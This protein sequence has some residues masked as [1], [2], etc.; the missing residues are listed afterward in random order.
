MAILKGKKNEVWFQVTAVG[1]QGE[2]GPQGPQGEP[3]LQGP[4]GEPGP[5]GPQG[6]PGLQGPQGPQGEIGPAGANGVDGFSPSAKVTQTETGATITITDKDGTTEATIESGSGGMGY[7]YKTPQDYGAV[8]NG[9]TDDTIAFQQA[10]SENNVVFVPEGT[11]KLNGTLV[12]RENCGLQ[13]S[14]RTLLKFGL[15][16]GNCIEMRGSASLQGNHGNI[17]VPQ[18]FTGNV[19]SV[20]T[21]LDGTNHAS[22]PPYQKSTPMWKRARYITDV[23]ITK[24]YR[25]NEN[26]QYQGAYLSTDEVSGT[27]LYISAN[28]DGGDTNPITY[29]WAMTCS[30]IRIAGAFEYG[31]NIENRD[32]DGGS[33]NE[34]DPAWNHDMRIEAVVASCE[35]GVRVYNCNT[36]HLAVTIQPATVITTGAPY[37]KNGIVLEDSKNIDLSSSIVWDWDSSNT[38]VGTNSEYTHIALYGNCRGLILS[39]FRYYEISPNVRESIYT[40]YSANYD[41]MI[42]LQEPFTRWFKPIEVDGEKRPYFYNGEVNQELCLKSTF[43]S[44]FG[45]Y[46]EEKHYVNILPV[47][48]KVDGEDSYS[49]TGW[50]LETWINNSGYDISQEYSWATGFIPITVN[51][52]IYIKGLTDLPQLVYYY[53]D[54]TYGGHQ[55]TPG[56]N[57]QNSIQTSKQRE[58]GIIEITFSGIGTRRYVRLRQY[59]GFVVDSDLNNLE[60]SRTDFSSTIVATISDNIKIDGSQ[61]INLDSYYLP[62]STKTTQISSASDNTVIPTA[63]AVYDYVQSAI[64]AALSTQ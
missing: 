60:V 4:Q 29:I 6:E 48:Q 41:N 42:V 43:E 27:G 2:T 21:G 12:I 20:D 24:T 64:A 38:L 57:G 32:K 36:A 3:G 35:T 55:N 17:D 54:K 34:K 44:V 16:T 51:E 30:G 7:P 14:Q 59:T 39:D 19:I 13:L 33:S 62:V 9:T 46:T 31:I 63:K 25:E 8:G 26:Q 1:P 18:S 52:T 5:Q 15:T 22:I 47:S 10:M 53:E 50:K 37:A 23:N 28:F 11:Y 61:V 40:N 56:L 45:S 58:D 49:A